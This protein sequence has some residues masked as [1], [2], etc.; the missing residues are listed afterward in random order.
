[1]PNRMAQSEFPVPVSGLD[2]YLT[3]YKMLPAKI[4]YGAPILT[5][6]EYWNYLG[7]F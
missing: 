2:I 6:C 5:K 3:K 1:M 7:C 4:A